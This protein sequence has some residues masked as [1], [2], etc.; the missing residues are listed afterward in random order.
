[1]C[2]LVGSLSIG[3]SH[4]LAGLENPG[5]SHSLMAVT[6][7]LAVVYLRWETEQGIQV[8]LVESKAMSYLM[9]I[10]FLQWKTIEG[11]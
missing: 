4:Q 8:R 3:A 9:Q 5:E 1:M 7:A 10:V 6:K 11:N 2:V